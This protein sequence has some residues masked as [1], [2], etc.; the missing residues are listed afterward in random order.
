[1]RWCQ[2]PRGKYVFVSPS[3]DLRFLGIMPLEP[4]HIRNYS[5]PG[6]VVGV[7]GI[8]VGFGSNFLNAIY[9]ERRLILRNG[10]HRAY[11]LRKRG[12]T[13]VPCIIQH[14]S[15]REELEVVGSSA[16]QRDPDLY[17]S[18][19]RPPMLRDYFDPDL[20]KVMTVQQR[21]HP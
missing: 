13:R 18:S 6:S 7:V 16:L 20:H 12:I 4:R 9:A 14:A 15:S 1:V 8:A 2:A 19:P 5:L 21:L 11:L 3:N 17:L 10:S